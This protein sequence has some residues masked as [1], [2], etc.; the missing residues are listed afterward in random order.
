M[1]ICLEF[2]SHEP[3]RKKL[4]SQSLQFC[5]DNASDRNNTSI[6]A[7]KTTSS[8]PYT[9]IQCLNEKINFNFSCYEGHIPGILSIKDAGGVNVKVQY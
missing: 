3:T 7:S 5:V 1:N 8:Y 6:K 2:L 9:A 4:D